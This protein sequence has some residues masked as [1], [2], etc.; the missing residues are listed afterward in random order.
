[1]ATGLISFHVS[2]KRLVTSPLSPGCRVVEVH[3][4][5]SR[6]NNHCVCLNYQSGTKY[7]RP[8]LPVNINRIFFRIYFTACGIQDVGTD[9]TSHSRP[10]RGRADIRYS[11]G[12]SVTR[13]RISDHFRA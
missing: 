7:T 5:Y 11:Y 3:G 8:Q 12:N 4:P 13:E 10:S 9:Y 6:Q 2:R 1:M